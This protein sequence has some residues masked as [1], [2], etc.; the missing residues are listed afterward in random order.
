MTFRRIG[1][2]RRC[3][4]TATPSIC[5]VVDLRLSGMKPREIAELLGIKR[6][7]VYTRLCMAGCTGPRVRAAIAAAAAPEVA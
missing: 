5:R 4:V 1:T 2:E 6:S 7:S 3:A